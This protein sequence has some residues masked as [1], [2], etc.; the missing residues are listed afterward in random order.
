MKIKKLM[1]GAAVSF[2]A[3]FTAHAA[4][5]PV[6]SETGLRGLFSKP[7]AARNDLRRSN[8]GADARSVT[9]SVRPKPEW[10]AAAIKVYD[11]LPPADKAAMH[12]NGTVF[13]FVERLAEARPDYNP[14]VGGLYDPSTRIVYV[15]RQGAC[16]EVSTRI[17]CKGKPPGA[18]RYIDIPEDEM[19][20]YARH[21]AGHAVD[22]ALGKYVTG[23]TGR[24]SAHPAFRAA[25]LEDMKSIVR[26][27]PGKTAADPWFRHFL[28]QGYGGNHSDFTTAARE[29]FAELW[30]GNGEIDSFFPKAAEFIKRAKKE[31][32]LIENQSAV[33]CT[34]GLDGV[35]KPQA[36]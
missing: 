3:V 10:R 24:V 4:D 27:F 20:G 29:A 26:N 15:M 22:V 23:A 34:Y 31:L 17:E 13:R 5:S 18:V 33:K 19:R 35:A 21:E 28:T 7:C 14:A 32:A 1:A 30:A 8:M 2:G 16:T 36:Q 25:V 9:F 12:A 6:F 11:D